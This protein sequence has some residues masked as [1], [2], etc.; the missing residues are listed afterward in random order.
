MMEKWIGPCLQEAYLTSRKRYVKQA[1][2][3]ISDIV[4]RSLCASQGRIE[5]RVSQM[6]I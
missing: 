4:P 2:Y 5:W 6:K 3:I 1:L